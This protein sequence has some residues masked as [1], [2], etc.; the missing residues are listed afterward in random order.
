MA[1]YGLVKKILIDDFSLSS[2]SEY[3]EKNIRFD[4]KVIDENYYGIYQI[5]ED[6]DDQ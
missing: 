5:E 1:R 3:I 4:V 2:L 6:N